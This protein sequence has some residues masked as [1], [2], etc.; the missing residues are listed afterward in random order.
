MAFLEVLSYFKDPYRLVILRIIL[1][2]QGSIIA[3]NYIIQILNLH[4][5]TY[6][7]EK[8][9]NHLNGSLPNLIPN[10]KHWYVY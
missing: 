2:I 7:L 1:R 10:I 5:F 4:D 6:T 3:H 9:S 8:K